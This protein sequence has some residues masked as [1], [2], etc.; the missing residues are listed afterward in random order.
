MPIMSSMLG[1]KATLLRSAPRS[2][3]RCRVY[4]K[5]G[6]IKVEQRLGPNVGANSL[7]NHTEPR[8]NAVIDKKGF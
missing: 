4:Q 5:K 2:E 8:V 1:N 7:P 6:M 3:R